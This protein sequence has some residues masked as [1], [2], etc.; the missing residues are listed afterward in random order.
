MVEYII[1]DQK[2]DHMILGMRDVRQSWGKGIRKSHN[3]FGRR[4]L[5]NCFELFLVG[6][7][8][9]AKWEHGGME[10]Q[11]WPRGGWLQLER[12]G[13][14]LLLAQG[15]EPAIAKEGRNR[16]SWSR[17]A[18]GD[19]ILVMTHKSSREMKMVVSLAT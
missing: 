10:L 15:A 13:R 7:F 16:I 4:R 14:P 8:Y 11:P 18:R 3:C 9:M 19:G 17:R 5:T 1:I 12:G 2:Q 6:W